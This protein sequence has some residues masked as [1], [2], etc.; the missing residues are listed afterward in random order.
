MPVSQDERSYLSAKLD[1][2]RPRLR[3]PSVLKTYTTPRELVR[4]NGRVTIGILMENLSRFGRKALI[5][6]HG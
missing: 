3:R 2:L 1:G 4:M 6:F 5:F